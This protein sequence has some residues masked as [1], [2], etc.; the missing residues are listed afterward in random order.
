MAYQR[1]LRTYAEKCG[2]DSVNIAFYSFEKQRKIVEVAEEI[3][4]ADSPL[5]SNVVDHI[6]CLFN[7][8]EYGDCSEY[9]RK[10][11]QTVIDILQKA[12][13][14]DTESST[15]NHRAWQSV[16]C[17]FDVQKT[18]C[19]IAKTQ[20]MCGQGAKDLIIQLMERTNHLGN[21]CEGMQPDEIEEIVEIM[22][23]NEEEQSALKEFINLK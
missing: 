14:D 4:D 9:A 22:E 15:D 5:H 6:G 19:F 8:T 16:N 1:C 11:L 23:L 3:C 10:K 7:V 21:S 18:A 20:E 17:V 13:E 12:E 2:E